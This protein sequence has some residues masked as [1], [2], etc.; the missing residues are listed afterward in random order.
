MILRDVA[1]LEKIQSRCDGVVSEVNGGKPSVNQA[2]RGT[3][4]LETATSAATTAR[5]E[6]CFSN[7]T[8]ASAK[9]SASGR[10]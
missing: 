5:A 7:W 9:A 1:V 2:L 6:R 3:S 10:N 4:A 8:L